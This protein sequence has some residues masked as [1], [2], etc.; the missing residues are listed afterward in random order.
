[1]LGWEKKGDLGL[2]NMNI[3]APMSE[4]VLPTTDIRDAAHLFLTSSNYR[5]FKELL[6][7][8]FVCIP[9]EIENALSSSFG[10]IELNL[11]IVKLSETLAD[12]E[13]ISSYIG[14]TFSA[15]YFGKSPI[16]LNL[17]MELLDTTQEVNGSESISAKRLLMWLYHNLFSLQ[18]VANREITP[19][20][21]V[22]NTVY[23]GAFM[24]MSISEDSSAQ[25]IGHVSA[26]FLVFNR[27]TTNPSNE[28]GIILSEILYDKATYSGTRT[29]LAT[30]MQ[31]LPATIATNNVTRDSYNNALLAVAD[32]YG[33][34][35]AQ[36]ISKDKSV[37]ALVAANDISAG[38]R[39]TA[40]AERKDS[41]K[42]LM[43]AINKVKLKH[44]TVA[45]AKALALPAVQAVIANNYVQDEVL[46]AGLNNESI[47][48]QL[49]HIIVSE[50]GELSNTPKLIGV[51]RTYKETVDPNTG[52]IIYSSEVVEYKEVSTNYLDDPELDF[53][54][55]EAAYIK[56]RKTLELKPRPNA[57]QLA[58]IVGKRD[59]YTTDYV[60]GLTTSDPVTTEEYVTR[61][62]YR[63]PEVDYTQIAY[64]V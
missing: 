49:T 37:M 26:R 36:R 17:E 48:K 47:E 59:V 64:S 3:L 2:Y 1:M 46:I 18:G 15:H 57:L 58:A 29:E 5:K 30:Y 20:L 32:K 42:S 35:E 50:E 7:D 62:E 19:C 27:V 41:K 13:Q 53:V 61:R 44:G 55:A 34:E 8:R 33:I 24:S 43:R 60:T 38:A 9:T 14:N 56:A 21:Q 45:A 52:E 54:V 16:I 63:V 12:Y 6:K 39:I 40:L 22:E 10:M 4:V 31:E 11:L 25:C 51:T 23:Y 28:S